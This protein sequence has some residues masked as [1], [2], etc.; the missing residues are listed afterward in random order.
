[1]PSNTTRIARNT[2]MLYFRQI[3]I[4][5]VSLYTVRVV[6]ETLGAED[7]GIYN[8]VAGV[9]TM[10]GFLSNSMAMATQRYLSFELGRNDFEQ[11]KKV[12]NVSL[13][14]YVLIM[15]AVLLLAETAGLWFVSNKLALPPERKSAALLVYQFAVISFLFTIL[16]APYMAAIIAHEDMNIYAYVS[17]VEV[18]LKLGLVFVLQFVAWDKLRLYGI[19]MSVATVINT[20]I[21][22]ITCM[23]KYKECKFKIYRNKNLF[24]ELKDYAAWNLFGSVSTMLQ[25][26]GIAVLLNQFF[27]PV[28]VAARGIAFSVNT[29]TSSFAGNFY[30]AIRPQIIKKYAANEKDAMMSLVFYGAKST[31]F[32]MYV[33][34]LPLILEMRYVLMLWLKNIPE[35]TVIFTSMAL[36]E[37]LIHSLGMPLGALAHAGGKIQLYQFVIYGIQLCNLPLAFVFFRSGAPPY[38]ISIIAIFLAIFCFIAQLLIVRY[39]VGFPVRMFLKKTVVPLFVVTILSPVI[40]VL[41]QKLMEQNFLRLIIVIITSIFSTCGFMYFIGL[42]KFERRKVFSLVLRKLQCKH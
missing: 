6:L 2:L 22:R 26:Q 35:Y 11:L 21:Y 27:N 19:L 5:L 23:V 16:T 24:K 20:A 28:V 17:I 41:T 13:V 31:Y 10:F 9:V 40:P 39:L 32:L 3:L 4:M 37:M 8:V 7:Y 1:M 18:V 29:A 36:I 12:F 38:I 14:I 34:T 25:N 15:I 30:N 33:F 42:N